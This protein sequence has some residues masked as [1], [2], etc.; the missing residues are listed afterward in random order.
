MTSAHDLL[1]EAKN[2]GIIDGNQEVVLHKL[3][4]CRNGFQHPERSQVQ[5]NKETVQNWRDTVFAV[6]GEQK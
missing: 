2:K 4:M 6:K 3:R 5:V 1:V